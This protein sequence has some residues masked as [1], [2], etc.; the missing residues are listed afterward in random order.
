RSRTVLRSYTHHFCA[1]RLIPSF[2]IACFMD[3][4]WPADFHLYL[5]DSFGVVVPT[6]DET[7]SQLSVSPDIHLCRL[8]DLYARRGLY[9]ARRSA[10][11]LVVGDT[12]SCRLP[13]LDDRFA[14][15]FGYHHFSLL[16][17]VDP[18]C[19]CAT[20][21]TKFIRRQNG[22]LFRTLAGG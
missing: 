17:S 6:L 8:G 2:R 11:D 5:Y 7:G 15:C 12:R 1:F 19:G 20:A 14:W 9:P 4:K 22:N 16:A 3:H 18:N 10:T 13:T 21:S